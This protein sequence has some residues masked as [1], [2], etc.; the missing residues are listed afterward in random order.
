MTYYTKLTLKM[1][2]SHN[3]GAFLGFVLL[4]LYNDYIKR[5][6]NCLWITKQS[7]YKFNLYVIAAEIICFSFNK[8]INN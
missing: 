4:I 1:C 7:E 2:F 3:Q 5:K 6:E 8:E